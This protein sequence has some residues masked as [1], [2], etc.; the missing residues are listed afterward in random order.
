M[1]H[2]HK[3]EHEH[4]YEHGH[5]HW[6]GLDNR[7]GTEGFSFLPI[8]PCFALL[9]PDFALLCA[10]SPLMA[11]QGRHEDE[12]S[13]VD[14]IYLSILDAVPRFPIPAESR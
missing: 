6:H 14:S 13:L 2:E 8:L 4:E 7:S 3:H 1:Q 9:S 11:S 10:A 12:N 5:W